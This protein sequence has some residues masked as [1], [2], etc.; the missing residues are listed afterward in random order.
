MADMKIYVFH[1]GPPCNAVLLKVSF[2]F[3]PR[4][5]GS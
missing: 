3:D 1:A 2:D 4:Q 5:P